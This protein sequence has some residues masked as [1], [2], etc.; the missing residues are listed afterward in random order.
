M[1]ACCICDEP[2]AAPVYES[3]APFSVTSLCQVLEG[4]TRVWHCEMCGHTQT[5]PLP[6]LEKFYAE[7]YHILTASEEE[8]QLY[9]IRNSQK[10][11]RTEHQVNTLLEI[12][13][14]PSNAA[15]LDLSLIHI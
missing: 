12:V 7:E 3:P 13:T 15:V 10:I 4:T 1:D 9:E 8:D 14:L 6:A 5:A 2:L 11:F